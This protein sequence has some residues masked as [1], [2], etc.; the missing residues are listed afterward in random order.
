MESGCVRN[1]MATTDYLDG[2]MLIAM[3]GIGDPR[4]E[5][6]VIFLCVHSPEGAMGLVV[7]KP[8]ENLTFT[9][10]LTRLDIV[11]EEEAIKLPARVRAMHVQFGGPVEPGRGFVL[12]TADY[13]ASD[14]TLPIDEGIGLTATLDVLR[15]I[16]KGKGPRKSLLALGYAGWGPGQLEHEIQQ[17]GW[18]HCEPNE[19][20][21]FGRDL[22]GKYALALHKI[23]V[24]PTMLSSSSGRA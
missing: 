22:D 15:A 16:A 6:T 2:Q 10:L 18:L 8:A 1:V 24:D 19:R 4:F 3:P 20:L 5:R 21:L 23:G 9:D 12:H 17:N 7:N 14:S 13:F 11:P